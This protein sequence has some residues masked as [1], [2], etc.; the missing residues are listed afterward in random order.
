MY[1][2]ATTSSPSCFVNYV[3]RIANKTV[4]MSPSSSLQPQYPGS[5]S[6]AS[7]MIII[8]VKCNSCLRN[9][10]IMIGELRTSR[11]LWCHLSPCNRNIQ[12]QSQEL[13]WWLS[14]KSNAMDVSSVKSSWFV[15]FW[16]Q[17]ANKSWLWCLRA[18]PCFKL[19][20]FLEHDAIRLPQC[21]PD[22]HFLRIVGQLQPCWRV[23]SS[24]D[25]VT[26]SLH[27]CRPAMG[28]SMRA[29]CYS[30]ERGSLHTI[31]NPKTYDVV[32]KLSKFVDMSIPDWLQGGNLSLT[33]Y[34]M[35]M[36]W[37]DHLSSR[38]HEISKD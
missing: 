28:S 5:E 26:S 12:I 2:S 38:V 36:S 19:L 21:S 31:S 20:H 25:T 27:T 15:N 6:R 1:V 13:R 16:L 24:L 23:M 8:Q 37:H 14:I 33:I 34:W 11:K 30:L 4:I 9:N 29:P 32:I 35:I 7:V 3:L 10:I 17:I 18:Q 22:W